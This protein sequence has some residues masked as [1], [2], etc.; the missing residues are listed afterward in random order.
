MKDLERCNIVLKLVACIL[1]LAPAGSIPL[2]AQP[3]APGV[4]MR[5]EDFST[6]P[7]GAKRLASLQKAV[8]VMKSLD[9]SPPGSVDFRR[10]WAYWANIHGYYGSQSPDGTVED[11]IQYLQ[12][13]GFGSYVSY[14]QGIIDQTPPDSVAQAVWAT[15]Q[16]SG[17]V[18]S[19]QAQNFF[20]W[21]RMYLYYFEQVLQWAAGDATLRLPYWNYTD[22]TQETIPANFRATSS[23]LY[24]AKRNPGMNAGTSKLKSTSTNIDTA[25]KISNYLDY[26]FQI[27]RNIHGYVHCTVG[28]TCPVAHMGDVPVAGNDP[29]FYTHHANI[30]RMFS[31]WEAKYGTPSGSWSTQTFSF[32]DATGTLQT[33]PVSDFLD[34]KALGYVY[35]NETACARTPAPR[36]AA[37]A[38]IQAS[39][40]E[41]EKTGAVVGS[42]RSVNVDKP[43]ISV[44]ITP[45][46]TPHAAL[47]AGPQASAGNYYLVLRDITAK[48]PPGTLLDVY[49]AKR[50]SPLTRIYAGTISWFNDFGVG[51]HHES[52]PLDKTLEFDVT[53]A[54]KKLGITSA[55]GL[56]VSL[57]A[58]SGREATAAAAAPALRSSEAKAFRADAH[59]QVGAIE[60][61]QGSTP[62]AQ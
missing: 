2:F 37:A 32:P 22:P 10:S 53:D 51:H 5:W 15:C 36:L 39:P 61:R 49:V 7:A 17:N 29:V 50:G 19:Q 45:A 31:C 11:Q 26:E 54:V 34:T 27:E 4:R 35:D 8:Q 18:Q 1:L 30:D 16:H 59:V 33:K 20:P 60:L 55:T 46:M 6:G 56:T 9:A 21:H 58:T 42:A 38:V 43:Q 52:G 23:V 14:Y 12:Q 41:V 62:P 47:K 44:D 28:P 57:V 3:P 24:D 25:L 40:S 48:S 13:N